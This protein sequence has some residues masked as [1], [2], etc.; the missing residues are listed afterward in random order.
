MRRRPF[1]RGRV[2]RTFKKK[3]FSW[4]YVDLEAQTLN[5][6]AGSTTDVVLTDNTDWVPGGLGVGGSGVKSM[7]FDLCIGMAWSPLETTLAYDT[8]GWRWGIFCLDADDGTATEALLFA[9]QRALKW[10]QFVFNAAEQPT[11]LGSDG[12]FRAYNRRVKAIQRFL[13][14]DETL[15]FSCAF[16]AAANTVI[17]GAELFIFGRM[18]WETP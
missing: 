3:Q 6:S 8:I 17:A 13:K 16:N 18:S 7:S 12:S 5:L 9:N 10:D 1:K 15:Q 4:K 11:A 14:Y 2:S